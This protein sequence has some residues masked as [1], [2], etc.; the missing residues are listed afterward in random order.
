MQLRVSEAAVA[1]VTATRLEGCW[2]GYL[3]LM[4]QTWR[5]VAIL[6]A[7]ARACR[8]ICAGST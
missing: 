6:S 8:L 2:K 1:S 5:E 7:S 3:R 4:P